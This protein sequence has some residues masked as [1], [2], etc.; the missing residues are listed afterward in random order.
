L[1]V[2]AS[3]LLSAGQFFPMSA[4]RPNIQIPPQ[5][6]AISSFRLLITGINWP[7]ETFLRR[8]IDGLMD[9]GVAVTIGSDNRPEDAQDRVEWL[10][11]PSWEAGVP[12]RLAQ[13]LNMAVRG[14]IRGAGD[15]KL[16]AASVRQQRSMVQQWRLWHQL[17]PY[18]GRRWD[19]IYI[20]WNTAAIDLIPIFDLSSP[21]VIS[22]RGTQVSVGPHNPQRALLRAG[23]KETFA[24]A[25]AVHCVSSAIL[26]E[27]RHMGLDPAKATVIRPA[28]DPELFVPTPARRHTDD[29][30]SVVTVGTL[31]WV[32]GHEWALQAVRRAVDS[33]INVQFDVIG[34]GPDRQR[35]LYTIG[36][37][38]L[39]K[40]VRCLGKLP[41]KEVLRR[42]QQAD[43]F[44]LSSLSE[45]ISNAVLE[46][47]SCGVPVVTTDCG[48]MREAVTDGVE[49]L[50]VPLRD[51]GAMA[52]AL[53]KLARDADLRQRMGE[54][55][56][57]RIKREF[58]L[59][60]Q[61]E[62]WLHLFRGVL[63]VKP[64]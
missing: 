38:G 22:C 27:A 64:T 1:Q 42:V 40:H 11:T 10:Q 6:T 33:G 51:A 59:S 32:K 36:D 61:I 53:V 41:P 47:M 14:K 46:A 49:G 16:F 45:G 31:I 34:D 35:V 43:A 25:A 12:L 20:P 63:R 30:F 52:A 9:S 29:V 8:L 17:L 5:K 56:R 48:G 18:A 19:A 3:N 26:K 55:G 2:V 44:L 13:M 24:R 60:N 39:E 15:M 54:A 62:Q 4:P 23:L 7:P 57:L 21:V 37:L 28:V 58:G 50:V